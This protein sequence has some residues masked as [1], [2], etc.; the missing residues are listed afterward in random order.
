[1]LLWLVR[2]KRKKWIASERN[3]QTGDRS[4]EAGTQDT[5]RR[6]RESVCES[7]V[8]VRRAQWTQS[9][10]W[11][12][13]H[14]RISFFNNSLFRSS[15]CFSIHSILYTNTHT[16]SL[17]FISFASSIAIIQLAIVFVLFHSKLIDLSINRPLSLFSFSPIPS[18]PT[19]SP[20]VALAASVTHVRRGQ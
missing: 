19:P 10:A 18:H 4:K 12:G 14:Q 1:M 11:P 5:E 20:S 3:R 2:G 13:I 17:L 16:H 9:K 15:G 6:E 7:V 8:C